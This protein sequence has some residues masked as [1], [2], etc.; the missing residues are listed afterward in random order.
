VECERKHR[1]VPSPFA[2]LQRRGVD[3]R[4]GLVGGEEVNGPAIEALRR[5]RE[6]AGDDRG[7]LGVS[8]RGVAMGE[9]G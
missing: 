4:L 6:H 7:V 8:Q 1:A 5:D 2:A 3:E 9:C